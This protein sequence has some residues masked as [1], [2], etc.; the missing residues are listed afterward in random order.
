VTLATAWYV[1]VAKHELCKTWYR[2]VSKY[3]TTGLYQSNGL[4]LRNNVTREWRKLRNEVLRNLS[5]INRIIEVIK[6]RKI[7]RRNWRSQKWGNILNSRN[8]RAE[9]TWETQRYVERRC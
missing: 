7:C 5:F 6:T 3:Q 4:G 2:P 9:T 1:G 8:S